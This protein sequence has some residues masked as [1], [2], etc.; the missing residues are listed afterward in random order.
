MSESQQ[1]QAVLAAAEILQSVTEPS[2]PE[3]TDVAATTQSH[4]LHMNNRGL[5]PT[6]P[7]L[8]DR[9]LVGLEV[10]VKHT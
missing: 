5:P 3:L 9:Q 1:G 10:S 7:K 8:V 4:Y 2:R 6:H